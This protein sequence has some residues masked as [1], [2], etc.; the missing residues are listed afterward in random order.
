[1][2]KV[3][4]FLSLLLLCPIYIYGSENESEVEY[5]WY[6][7]KEIDVHYESDVLNSCEYFDKDNFI[8]S[9]YIYSIDE[10]LEKEG[11]IIEQ[12]NPLISV[13]RTFFNKIDITQFFIDYRDKV[14]ITEINF[15]NK[16]DEVIPF[17]FLYDEY[18]SLLDNDDNTY[19]DF[20][21]FTN[22]GVTFDNSVDVRDFKIIIKYIKPN[23]YFKGFAFTLKLTDE[24][25]LNA[26]YSYD[27]LEKENCVNNI[28][29]L[30]VMVNYEN[31]YNEDISFKTNLYRFKDTL[32][33]C[34]SLERVYVPGFYKELDGFIKD[35][36]KFR[37]IENV[38]TPEGIESFPVINERE[39]KTLSNSE[40]K[41]NEIS[42]LDKSNSSIV[43]EDEK[44][45][46]KSDSFY[47]FVFLIIIITIV[48]IFLLVR[49]IKKSR[50]KI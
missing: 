9:D 28:C 34:Y 48:V 38:V 50:T 45:D 5:R 41:N 30:E 15:V 49:N 39:P 18:G 46:E 7:L 32:Y 43:K 25:N 17:N 6:M 19:I 20:S 44:V 42:F 22:I 10:P 33:K 12:V 11:R 14:K 13:H 2:K 16:K 1:M 36:E 37:L 35:E 23:N 31:M 47:I 24:I 21:N 29:T 27:E 26:F 8:Y 40:S 3:I 4:G